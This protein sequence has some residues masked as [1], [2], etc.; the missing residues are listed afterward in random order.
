MSE[1]IEDLTESRPAGFG[2]LES[3]VED[4]QRP[5][6]RLSE[7]RRGPRRELVHG[8]DPGW[9]KWLVL[10]TV[11]AV[12]LANAVYWLGVWGIVIVIGL[13]VVA[14]LAGIFVRLGQKNSR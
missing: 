11:A 4:P 10:G 5:G 9:V 6:V 12:L 1:Q 2:R 7:L 8:R 14:L 13:A 3:E